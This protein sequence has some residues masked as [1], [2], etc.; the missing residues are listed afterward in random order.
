MNRAG[1]WRMRQHLLCLRGRSGHRTRLFPCGSYGPV[2]PASNISRHSRNLP[3][4]LKPCV[5]AHRPTGCQFR[6]SK[7]NNGKRGPEEKLESADSPAGSSRPNR[8]FGA[9]LCLVHSVYPRASPCLLHLV[10]SSVKW[11]YRLLPVLLETDYGV[12]TVW[13][14]V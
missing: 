14:C 9:M 10:F 4:S 3:G 13:A 12:K 2:S 5:G 6:V 1:R 8:S 11:K 7:K